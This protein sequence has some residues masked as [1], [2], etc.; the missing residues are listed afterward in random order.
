MAP[1]L[2]MRSKQMP[3]PVG[4]IR[5][6]NLLGRSVEMFEVFRSMIGRC[7]LLEVSGMQSEA[8]WKME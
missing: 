7:E 2:S 6:V 5:P 4:T 3:V 8:S 1:L